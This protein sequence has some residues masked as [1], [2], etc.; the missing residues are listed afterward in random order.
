MHAW[1]NYLNTSDPKKRIIQH[2]IFWISVWIFTSILFGYQKQTVSMA[3]KHNLILLPVHMLYFYTIA[4]FIIPRYL[5]T[6][7][8]LQFFLILL[9]FVAAMPLV[10]RLLDIFVVEP[11]LNKYL[12]DNKI[13]NW[14]K[15]RGTKL[16]RFTNVLYYINAFKSVNLIVWFAI[17]LKFFNLWYKRQQAALQAELNLLKAQIHPHFLFNTLNNLYAHT[18]SN[19]PKSPEIVLGLSDILRYMLYECNAEHVKLKKDIEILDSYILIEKMRYED[20]LEFN[21]TKEGDLDHYEIAPLLMLP[22]VENAF[23]Y[24]ANEKVG[25][26]WINMELSVN[27]NLLKFKIMNG[28]VTH[29]TKKDNLGVGHIGLQNVH[30]RLQ[31]IYPNAHQLKIIDEEEL[32][33]VILTIDLDKRV[34]V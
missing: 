20:R 24:G 19:S 16:E 6:K 33:A 31:L 21:F 25:Q 3:L 2:I 8:Y 23:K 4:Y 7:K 28:K 27:D 11:S 18:L 29:V 13:Y 12:I 1:Y 5:F 26:A 17:A 22:L 34:S 9:L 15:V 10:S 14:E 32:F 30:K